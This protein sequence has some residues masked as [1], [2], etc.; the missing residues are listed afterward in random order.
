MTGPAPRSYTIRNRHVKTAGTR[1]CEGIKVRS[2]C[3]L[4]FGLSVQRKPAEA[5]K[6]NEHDL[7]GILLDETFN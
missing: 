7:G 4:E 5:V 3:P 1:P 6:D 2:V